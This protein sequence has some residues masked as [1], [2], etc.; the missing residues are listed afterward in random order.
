MVNTV[1]ER[2]TCPKCSDD[3]NKVD[4]QVALPQNLR[5][6]VRL[7]SDKT[8]VISLTRALPADMYYCENCRF[9]ELYAT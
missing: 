8:P 4:V 5:E 3:M 6:G 1:N 7:S 9:I 2:K